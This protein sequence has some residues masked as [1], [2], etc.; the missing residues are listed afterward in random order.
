[1]VCDG[2]PVLPTL[3]EGLCE[4]SEDREFSE[5]RTRRVWNPPYDAVESPSHAAPL[6][7]CTAITAVAAARL[8]HSVVTSWRRRSCTPRNVPAPRRRLS[9]HGGAPEPLLCAKT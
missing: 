9:A 4:S 7:L 3:A 1:M 8:Y 2:L 6:P 5:L